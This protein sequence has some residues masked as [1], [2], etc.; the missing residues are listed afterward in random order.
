MALLNQH[1]A[2]HLDCRA[3]RRSDGLSVLANL[4]RLAL[5]TLCF[6]S[7]GVCAPGVPTH[8]QEPNPEYV[9]K[10]AFLY[11]FAKFVDWPA[12]TF[13]ATSTPVTIC[14]VGDEPFGSSLDAIAGKI[15]QKRALAIKRIRAGTAVNDCQILFI[16]PSELPL[17]RALAH[18]LEKAPVLTVCDLDAC[19]EQ[20][21]MI[22][23][24]KENEKVRLV[25]NLS[26][27]QRAELKVSS[28]LIKLATLVE[29]TH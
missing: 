19:A 15:V 6:L 2:D 21:I 1:R 14:T 16:S 26:S 25:V 27:I 10:A 13:P 3:T 24:R 12:E 8:A 9:L 18:S 4:R 5:F 17:P 23:L 20:G 22:E 29:R 11:N 7:F 28:H